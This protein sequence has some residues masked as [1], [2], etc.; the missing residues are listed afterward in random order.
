MISL[1]PSGLGCPRVSVIP[2]LVVLSNTGC[3]PGEPLA[4]ATGRWELWVRV[5]ET[6]FQIIIVHPVLPSCM[7]FPLFF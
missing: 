6:W 1:L 4:P 7:Y 3:E 2:V 5:V